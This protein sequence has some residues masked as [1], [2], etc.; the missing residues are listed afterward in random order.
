MPACFRLLPVAVVIA[1]LVACARDGSSA[2]PLAA[3]L[4][5]D[6][7]SIATDAERYTLERTSTG[8]SGRIGY[9]FTN[10]TDR[11]VSLL[12]CRGGYALELQ[13][14]QGDTW[15]TAWSPVLLQCLSPPL[16]IQPGGSLPGI[17]EIQAGR[18][19]SNYYPQFSS[20]DIDGIYRLVIVS[21][22]WNY[23]HNGPPW[24]EPIPVSH[25]ASDPFE[26]RTHR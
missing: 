19:G 10:S 21:A 12:N 26:I 8:W 13:K 2:T 24:G 11:T 7:P 14:R 22:Y 5:G 23:D 1:T 6:S 17:L 4:S 25:R 9:R 18:T 3:L 15:V 16:R 20:D